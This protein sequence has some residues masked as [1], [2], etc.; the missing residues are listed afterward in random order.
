[1]NNP[2]AGLISW[3]DTAGGGGAWRESE[4]EDIA[5]QTSTTEMQRGEKEKYIQE[6]RNNYKSYM[7]KGNTV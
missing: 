3:L 5:I 1:M 2:F 6:S 7:H 4:L